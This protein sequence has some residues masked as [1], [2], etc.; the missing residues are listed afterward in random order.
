[1][2]GI[3]IN[4]SNV[5]LDLNGFTITGP[6][7]DTGSSGYG[8]Y[9]EEI[10]NVTIKS[11]TIT[12]FRKSGINIHGVEAAETGYNFL[13]SELHIYLNGQYGVLVYPSGFENGIIERCNISQNGQ[14]ET[15]G[16]IYADHVLIK[17]NNIHHNF[18]YGIH[19]KYGNIIKDNI[20][21]R[22]S[23]SDDVV[24]D[25][26][27]YVSNSGGRN[28]ISENNISFGAD[29]V[30]GMVIVGDYNQV[31]NNLVVDNEVGIKIDGDK[32]FIK[33]NQIVNNSTGNIDL[34]G[35]NNGLIENI[36]DDASAFG[37]GTDNKY[38][39]DTVGAPSTAKYNN[40]IGS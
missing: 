20:I 6:G 10:H 14:S 19:V 21:Y 27:I 40:Y 39:N 35:D 8:I 38:G 12:N 32:N 34:N 7:Y 29:D 9:C 11:G 5:T 33:E 13:L 17:N 18:G 37:G 15:G 30:D 31:I 22:T 26:G 2:N 1:M 36:Y 23:D 4:V 28:I 24:E 16:G 3:E 25:S